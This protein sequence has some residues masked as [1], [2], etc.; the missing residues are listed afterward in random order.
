MGRPGAQQKLRH[1]TI[2]TYVLVRSKVGPTFTFF[3]LGH[4]AR[5]AVGRTVGVGVERGGD[6]GCG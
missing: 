6:C 1:D 5:G 3:A 4:K 2:D